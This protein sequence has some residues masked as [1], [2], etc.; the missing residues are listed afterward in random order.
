MK[1][2]EDTLLFTYVVIV[3]SN[4]PAQHSDLLVESIKE[5]LTSDADMLI[6]VTT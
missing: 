6:H 4:I 1:P 5:C 3:H 2:N